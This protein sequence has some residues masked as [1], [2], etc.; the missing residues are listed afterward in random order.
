M[1]LVLIVDNDPK[2]AEVIGRAVRALGRETSIVC[3]GED[4]LQSLGERL[5][6]LV[7]IDA[8]MPGMSGVQTLELIRWMPGR[9]RMVPVVLYGPEHD[10]AARREGQ[11][12][13]ANDFWVT[14]ELNFT[15]F[16]KMLDRTVARV[17]APR[18]LADAS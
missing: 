10:S 11:R 13:G 9:A 8:D 14:S 12:L 6:D 16:A 15:T 5:P 17:D 3:S 18:P 4:A 7:L 2:T 1:G